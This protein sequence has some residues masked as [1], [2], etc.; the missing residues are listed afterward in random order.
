MHPRIEPS[1]DEVMKLQQDA[2]NAF[3]SVFGQPL[4]GQFQLS[5]PI[6]GWFT[7]KGELRQVRSSAKLSRDEFET[8]TDL[9]SWHEI[10]IPRE[11]LRAMHLPPEVSR[12]YMRCYVG[13]VGNKPAYLFWSSY[14]E[15]AM[16]VFD[17]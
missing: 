12:D 2:W 15:T 8:R 6:T 11:Y 13:T 1:P 9:K 10:S 14:A 16:L 5:G 4:P 3:T 17:Y 7:E